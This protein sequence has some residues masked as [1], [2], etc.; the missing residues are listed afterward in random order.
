MGG[1]DVNRERFRVLGSD[2]LS[3]SSCDCRLDFARIHAEAQRQFVT[4]IMPAI[5]EI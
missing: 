4:P 2:E 5:P 3:R 1:A